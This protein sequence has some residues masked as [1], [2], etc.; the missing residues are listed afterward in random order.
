[1]QCYGAT[2]SGRLHRLTQPSHLWSILVKPE[3]RTFLL[4]AC[5][6]QLYQLSVRECEERN[7]PQRKGKK[8]KSFEQELFAYVKRNDHPSSLRII[9][10][11]SFNPVVRLSYA[12]PSTPRCFDTCTV[13]P[14]DHARGASLVDDPLQAG[15]LVNHVRS[16]ANPSWGT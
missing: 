11:R 9:I 1:M 13:L 16:I 7:E 8:K 15:Y 4:N 2:I 10:V 6:I 3:S 14:V 5:A 12:P